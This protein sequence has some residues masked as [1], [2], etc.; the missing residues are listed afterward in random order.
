MKYRIAPSLVLSFM[1]PVTIAM[2]DETT[3]SPVH[4]PWLAADKYAVTHFDPAQTDAFPYAVP[5]GDFHVDLKKQPRIV[6]GPVNIMTLA[7]TQPNY[8]WAVSSEGL[9]F[10]DVSNDGFREV[11]RLPAPGQ[12]VIPA[13]MHAQVLGQ[14]YTNSAQ[15]EKAVFKEYGL[16][17]KR[18]VNGVYSVVD[19]DNHVYYNT[20]DGKVSVF[21][22][23]DESNP[24]AGIKLIKTVDMKPIIGPQ[25]LL[26]GTG[27]TYDGKF[28]VASNRTVSVFDLGLEGKPQTIHLGADEHVTNSFAIDE[29]NGIYIASDKYMRKLVW[30]GSR[31]SDNEA[32]GAWKAAYDHGRA[33]PTVKIG[34]GTGS[35]PTLMGFGDDADKLVVITDGADHMKLTAFWRDQIPPGWKPVPGA[36]SNRIAGQIAVTAGL[37]PLPEFVQSEQSVVVDGYGAFVVNNIAK[38]GEKDKLVDVLALGPVNQPGTGCERFE[39]DPQ[40]HQW[41]SIWA[42]ADIVSTSMV[43]SVSSASHMVFVNGY[44][45]KT[46]WEITGLD[47]YTG[48]TVQRV[49]FGKDNL[50]N[51]AYAIIQYA[52]DGDLIFNSIGGPTRVALKPR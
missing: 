36:S 16:D 17:W 40:T 18:A 31:L 51:G 30:T 4:N 49:S 10:V 52:P 38:S 47:W 20:A 35:T 8:M 12:K 50:G 5:K 19:K 29:K 43:P 48:K 13:S 24:A 23:V 41:R 22:L 3:S 11:A 33:P 34:T 37:K 14:T 7:S 27:I 15:V 46:G 28:V 44:Y 9:T 25:D 42:R 45:K 32:D 6:G 21:G 2:A 39:W 1:F 26:V